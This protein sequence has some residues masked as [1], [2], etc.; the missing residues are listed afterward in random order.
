MG[1]QSRSSALAVGAAALLASGLFRQGL[2]IV[3]LAV[4]ARLLTPEDF[5]IVAYFLV[6]LGLLEMMQRQI[7]MVLIRLETV[8]QAHLET[9]FTVQLLFG[10]SVAAIFLAS[11]PLVAMVGLPQLVQLTPYL[12]VLSL[13]IA[14]RSPL[15]LI[16]ERDLTFSYAA[17]EETFSRIAYSIAAITLAWIWRDYWAIV[18][19]TFVGVAMRSFYTFATAPMV[20]RLS[21][22]RWRDNLSFSSWSMTAQLAQF[23]SQNMPQLIIGAT[24]GLSDAGLFRLGNRFTS[25]ATS[26]LFA[27]LLR[28]I[29]PALADVART[30]DRKHEAFITMNALVIAVLLPTG[31]G[32]ALVAEDLLVIGVGSKWIAAAQVI[33][34]LAPLKAL[35]A[36]QDN[37]RS[38]SYVD[39]STR[40]L[41]VRS[42]ILLVVVTV[43]MLI[44]VNYGFLGALIAAGACSI[45]S[46]V[47]TLIMAKRF[48][49]GGFFHPLLAAW[50]SFVS[51]AV[52]AL[53]VI[54]VG[55]IMEPASAQAGSVSVLLTKIIVGVLI[56]P[57]THFA[58]WIAAGRPEGFESAVLRIF[59]RL[60]RKVPP[61]TRPE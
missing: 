7:A 60:R 59:S 33:W 20:P 45:A 61:P 24:L 53:A 1:R 31:I 6:A 17:K 13:V 30:T 5:G 14:I 39:G 42:A 32:M 28:V 57:A 10:L 41:F 58:L 52:M 26:Q 29:Y 55:W 19:A 43:L 51:C 34:I 50:R 48:G 15:F 47:T 18:Y 36:L 27:P 23:M 25:L 46:L 38:A 37:V 54:C 49:A 2:G 4:T 21:L 22:A 40:F 3:T 12:A 11:R 35:E 44:G 8:T 16:Y 9:V 56:Y